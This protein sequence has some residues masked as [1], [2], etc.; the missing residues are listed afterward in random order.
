LLAAALLWPVLAA[1]VFVVVVLISAF[2]SHAPGRI[3]Y[4]SLWHGD[5]VKA[6][7]TP[8]GRIRNS[9]QP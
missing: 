9:G 1:P 8:D 6:L 7:R 3:R 4:Y 2:F 5:V